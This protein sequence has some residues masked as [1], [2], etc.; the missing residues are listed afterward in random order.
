M[1]WKLSLL[2]VDDATVPVQR[3]LER[4]V[5]G[6][7]QP[8]PSTNF[9]EAL[10]ADPPVG[11]C[12]RG[13]RTSL[14]LGRPLRGLILGD[15]PTLE[16]RLLETFA[17]HAVLAVYLH[18]TDNSYAWASWDPTGRRV[19]ARAGNCDGV[20][21]DEG[22]PTATEVRVLSRYQR[23]RDGT[24]VDEHG[25]QWTHDTLGEEVVFGLIAAATD[26]DVEWGSPE[27]VDVETF[28]PGRVTFKL[29]V[30]GGAPVVNPSPAQVR[31]ALRCL[32]ASGPSFAALE[33][34]SG[35]YVQAGGSTK[36]LVV[37]G[38]IARERSFRHTSAGRDGPRSPRRH[39]PM[40][41]GGVTVPANEVLTVDDAVAVFEEF[42]RT[43]ALADG[44]V[45][46]D[47]T[48]EFA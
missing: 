22:T 16:A 36:A 2:V 26:I 3:C 43:E 28:E 25:E 27:E 44:F 10:A 30:E 20:D 42:L 21:L 32:R 38:R 46:R 14:F 47:R 29:E 1:S 41:G 45:W 8:G 31:D 39:V 5:G 13:G 19:R 6:P 17:G 15:D 48:S 4:L 12:A 11:G 24:F 7:L 35:S 40:S 33:A 9:L 34:A 37:E 23:R 18:G